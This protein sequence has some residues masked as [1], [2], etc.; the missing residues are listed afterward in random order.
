MEKDKIAV[1]IPCFNEEFTI[2]KVVKDAL[3]YVPDATIYVY[4]NNSTDK[5]PEIAK[6]AGAV[7]RHEYKQGKGNV[8]RRMFR[9][10]DAECYVLID[11][12]DTYPLE[13]VGDMIE[14]VVNKNADMV[15]GDRLSG[16]YFIENKR[17]FHNTGNKMVRYFVNRLFKSN[18]TDIMTGFRVF[19]YSFVKTFPV[20][21]TGFEIETE[22][23]I[24]GIDKGLNIESIPVSY[25]D[26]PKGSQSKLNTYSDGIKVLKTIFDL[27]RTYRPFFFFGIIAVVLFGAS[28]AFFIPIL[29]EYF[30]T[31][32]VPR[33]PTLIV[34][35][36]TFILAIQSL[37]C[38]ILLDTI[39]KK[40]K[41]DF[42]IQLHM[43]R[44]GII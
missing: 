39:R 40:D 1:L 26:R 3:C 31:G 9:E 41:Q 15:I 33:F 35:G 32:L 23:S 6:K 30:D 28:V 27:Y 13:K 44:K 42:E 34:C 4:D 14:L 19:S 2:G 21:T 7:I 22:M 11:G 38:G 8:I 5:T 37:W 24:H 25:K 43:A 18:L 36:F 17:I 10:I 20:L 29:L 12:D 16:T